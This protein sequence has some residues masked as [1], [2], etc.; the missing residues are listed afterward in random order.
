[1]IK[2]DNLEEYVKFINSNYFIVDGYPTFF[3]E[4]AKFHS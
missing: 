3:V 2:F 4:S 1:M